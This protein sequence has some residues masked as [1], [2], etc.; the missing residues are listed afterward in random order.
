MFEWINEWESEARRDFQSLFY[1]SLNYLNFFYNVYN[2]F[3]NKIKTCK[4]VLFTF[5]T[6]SL[7][8]F[9]FLCFRRLLS[10][11]LPLSFRVQMKGCLSA[12]IHSS[13]FWICGFLTLCIHITMSAVSHYVLLDLSFLP[14]GWEHCQRWCD[15]SNFLQRLP[16]VCHIVAKKEGSMA[17]LSCPT[18]KH[19][20][21][22]HS[23][24]PDT[25]SDCLFLTLWMFS[26]YRA[27]A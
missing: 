13:V 4:I 11:Q 24:W 1:T 14:G 19:W 5:E 26:G 10:F 20:S 23:H 9:S 21:A 6:L 8:L 15:S 3:C 2:C 22:L 25:Q 17:G 12:A 7:C 16:R 18:A 27:L